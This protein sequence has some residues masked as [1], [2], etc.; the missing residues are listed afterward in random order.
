MDIKVT[1]KSGT[2]SINVKRKQIKSIRLRVSSE[3]QIEVSA[4]YHVRESTIISFVRD[5]CDFVANRLA[6]V[7]YKRACSYPED[8]KNGDMFSLLGRRVL[9]QVE[10]G[11]RNSAQLLGSVLTIKTTDPTDREVCRQAFIS[12]A[13][14]YAKKV[15]SDRLAV[16]Q[17]AFENLRHKNIRI[18]VRDMKTRWG[19]INV[20]KDTMSLSVHLLR[21]E[22]E[23]VDHIILHELCHYSHANHSSSFYYELSKH[24]PNYKQMQ[25]QLKKYGM[26]G[27]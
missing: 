25:R 5:N 23:L 8:Y 14:R 10:E 1:T 21:C 7:E 15:F 20:K 12:W 26:V 18:S 17:L 22:P 2:F 19:S 3:S 6:E 16:L 27:F 9:L 11:G 24:S 13:K 4:P